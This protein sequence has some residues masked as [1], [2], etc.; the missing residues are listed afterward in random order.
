MNYQPIGAYC[1]Y[2]GVYVSKYITRNR[3]TEMLKIHLRRLSQHSSYLVTTVVYVMLSSKKKNIAPKHCYWLLYIL[4][5]KTSIGQ[6]LLES[7][8]FYFF[9]Y[10][11]NK[12]DS[13]P[14]IKENKIF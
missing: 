12:S 10:L 13:F 1:R 14:L 6:P 8:N 2:I 7:M 3:N 5:S 9:L 4:V 11:N